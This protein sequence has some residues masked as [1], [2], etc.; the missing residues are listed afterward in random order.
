MV[1]VEWTDGGTGEGPAEGMRAHAD[2][3]EGATGEVRVHRP[4]TAGA[5]VRERGSDVEPGELALAAGSVVGPPQIGLLAAIGCSTVVV[6]PR[7][8]WSSCPPAAN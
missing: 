8:A 2:A 5:H 7:P 4:V 1:P 6:R 3:P